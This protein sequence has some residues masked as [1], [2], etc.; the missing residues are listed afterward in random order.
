MAVPIPGASV[1][2]RRSRKRR[3]ALLAAAC[4]AWTVCGADAQVDGETPVPLSSRITSAAVDVARIARRLPRVEYLGGRFLRRPRIV[5]VTFAGDDLAVVSRLEQFGDTITRTAWWRAV[6]EGYCRGASDCI[7]DGRPGLPIRLDETLPAN[8]HAVDLSAL[9]TR[10]ARAGRLG[11]FDRD[12]LLLV[13]LPPGVRLSDAFARYCD[14]GPRAFHRSLRFDP[15]EIPYAVMPRCGDEATLT[16]TASHELLESATNP[17]IAQ[18]GFA[19]QARSDNVGFT[20]AGLEPMDPCG[21]LSV[22]APR[23]IESGF[24][25]QRAWSNRAASMGRDPCVPTVEGRPYVALVP[26][27]AVVQLASVDASAIVPLVAAADRPV[28]D[29]TISVVTRSGFRDGEPC[30]DASL[31]RTTVVPGQHAYLTV[32]RRSPDSR[33]LCVVGLV[34]TL[35]DDTHVWPMAVVLR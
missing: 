22:E 15:A 31:D 21:L 13:Y 5:T 11:A 28:S 29:W 25:V 35:G 18:R 14:G 27:Q 10:H 9:L 8:V 30:V 24:L 19:L 16:A 32:T 7:G 17:N 3:L 2:R 26:D 4:V 23:T 34:S 20:A 6:T 1:E 33:R 12:T